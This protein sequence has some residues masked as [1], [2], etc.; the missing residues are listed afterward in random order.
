MARRRF[1]VDKVHHGQ[2]ELAGD[3][4]HHLRNVLR[5]E[6]GQ[7]YEISDNERVYLAEV[8]LSTKKRVV[9]DLQ[10]E[11][12]A[13]LPPARL[14]LYLALVKFDRFE[15]AV[16]KA[17]E[18]GAARIV[19]VIANRSE[20]GLEKAVN[21]RVERWRKIAH[22]A[23]QQSRRVRQPEVAD[24]VSF[25]AAV[26]DES[27]HRFFL[28]EQDGVPM[29]PAVLPRK[30]DDG[31]IALLIGPEGG[32][33]AAER[34]LVEKGGWQAVSLGPQILRTETAAIAAL[35]IVM[36]HWAQR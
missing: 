26:K 20:R 10:E 13:I 29:L 2:A 27:G 8:S 32:W 18:L 4:A 11:L 34:D 36:A 12:P 31:E 30:A 6:A 22:E 5:V 21:K 9:F 25:A 3:Q 19:P 35:A 23:S 14:H 7:R 1:F 24:A 17:T 15:L 33:S 28:E 16:E